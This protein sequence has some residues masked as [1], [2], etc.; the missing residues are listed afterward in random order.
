MQAETLK[1]IS[2]ALESK[3]IPYEFGEYTGDIS[4]LTQ[5]WVGEY[6]EIDPTTEDGKND[7]TFILTGNSKDSW[8]DLDQTKKKIQE[9]FPEIGGCVTALDNGSMAVIFYSRAIL[10]PK[11]EGAMKRM[12]INLTVKEWKVN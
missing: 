3:N 8:N 12:Q 4:S 7:S 6:Q 9:L 11:L 1:F 10:L 5:F 2:D